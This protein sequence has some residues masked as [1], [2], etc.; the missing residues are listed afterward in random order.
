MN[1]YF[2]DDLIEDTEEIDLYR[3]WNT[4]KNSILHKY[5]TMEK[6][7]IVSSYLHNDEKCKITLNIS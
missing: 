4:K 6:L 3:S 1:F 2:Q 5:T 7:S